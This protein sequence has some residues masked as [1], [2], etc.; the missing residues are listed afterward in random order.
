[1]TAAHAGDR[2]V[3]GLLSTNQTRRIVSGLLTEAAITAGGIDRRRSLTAAV[4]ANA[5]L[6]RLAGVS[7]VSGSGLRL[8]QPRVTQRQPGRAGWWLLALTFAVPRSWDASIYET[9]FTIRC[10]NVFGRIGVRVGRQLA[11]LD[12]DFSSDL[13]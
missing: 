4:E 13:K 8:Y 12:R 9:G 10:R 1:M 7:G 11:R 3:V 5:K 6:G 2:W